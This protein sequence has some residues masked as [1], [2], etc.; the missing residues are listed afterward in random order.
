MMAKGTKSKKS[1]KKVID[2]IMVQNAKDDERV[3][4]ASELLTTV[5][6]EILE[7]QARKSQCV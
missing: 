6:R 2:Q 1:C 3:F 5:V 7:L 4:S